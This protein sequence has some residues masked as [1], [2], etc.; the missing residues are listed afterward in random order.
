MHLQDE[1]YTLNPIENGISNAI[2][3]PSEISKFLVLG[4]QLNI[5]WVICQNLW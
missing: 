2:L 3:N 1:I 5:Q 4:D